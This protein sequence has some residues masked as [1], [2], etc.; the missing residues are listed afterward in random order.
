MAAKK[1]IV[2][3]AGPGGLT[4]AMLCAHRGY[5]VTVIERE[6]SV[7]GRNCAITENGYTYDTGPT[8]LMMDFILREIFEQTGRDV[9]KYCEMVPLD[10]MYRLSFPD[11]T[12]HPT[13]DHE[14]MAEEIARVFPDSAPGLQAFYTKEKKR[15]EMMYPCLNRPYGGY[16]SLFSPP[17]IKALPYLKMSK[18][19]YD[20]LGTYFSDTLCKISFTFQAKYLGMSPWQCPALFTIIPYIEHAFGIYHVTGG[21]SRISDAMAKVVHEE[22]GR[23]RLNTTVDKVIVNNSTATGVVLTDGEKIAADAVVINADFGY[24]MNELFEK[25]ILKKYSP[26]NVKKKKYSCSTFMLYLGLDTIYDEPHH[27]IIIAEDYKKNIEDIANG[28]GPSDDMSIYV[29]NA[30]ITD[31]T[32]APDGHS[33]V[34]VLVPVANTT[35]TAQWND[36]VTETY[37][38]KVLARIAQRTSMK[39]ITAHIVSKKVITPAGWQNDYYLYNG[40][41]FN[42]SHN[43]GQMLM[44]RPHNRFEEIQRCYLVG[45]GTHPGSGLPTIYESGRISSRLL[46]QDLST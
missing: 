19:L 22:G 27:N 35:G 14:K 6:D 23:I 41:T 15:Y 10:P 25:G 32:L 7:G 21:L 26:A 20:N 12:F 11:R 2:I 39:D 38:N 13:S 43:L 44:F 42:L 17:L 36:E 28:I 1:V 40:A 31:T 24:A 29:R 33:A 8:F 3:G 37:T 18:N 9:E 34:Y 16:G 46:N 4:A 30:S 5:D 45:G